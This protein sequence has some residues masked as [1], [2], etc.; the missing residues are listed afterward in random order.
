MTQLFSGAGEALAQIAM[1]LF[2]YQL[3]GSTMMVGL[4]ALVLIL[5]RVVL[6]P[7]TGL[8]A[9]RLDR[10]RLMMGADA[11]RLVLV[12]LVPL[13]QEIWHL[14]VLAAAIA[15]GN[16]V[17]RP[18]EMAA[19]PSV[20][21]PD[22]LVAA[23]SLLQVSNGILRIAVPAVGAGFIVVAGP[24]PVFWLQAA[25][26]GGS[27]AALWRLH[28]PASSTSE[29]GTSA[30]P[31]SFLHNARDEVWSG[32]R[33]IRAVPIVRGITGSEAI[34]QLAPAAMTVA[35]VVYA[36][37]TLDLGRWSDAAFALMTTF[38]SLGV[39]LGALMARHIE[40]RIG[41]PRMMA[42]GYIA[43]FFLVVA[44]FQPAMPFIY[45]AWFGY[46][47][48]DALAEVSFQA[49][50]AEA[51]PS[52]LQGRVYAV[53][54]AIVALA[55]A[56]AFYAMGLLTPWLGAP[57]TLAVAGVVVGIG[58]PAALW[59]TGAIRSVQQGVALES[60]R[61]LSEPS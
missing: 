29:F 55:G 35:G 28:I 49:Y 11:S 1:P 51:V 25:C 5:P 56:T 42:L 20:A 52:R 39:V 6:A 37:Q 16:A 41:R 24:A 19:V 50:L 47:V 43:P 3:T 9:D 36:A 18:A 27:L 44:V 61:E 30:S 53:W 15:I 34:H 60:A 46:G 38:V 40:R 21:G 48:L 58:A 45:A 54:G 12:S 26:F 2:I 22:R 14:V 7:I 8:V 13:T 32:L 10:R 33:V 31:F 59:L 57:L 4:I 23:I 17:G